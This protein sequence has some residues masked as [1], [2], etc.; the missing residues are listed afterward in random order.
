VIVAGSNT[1][2][3][4]R[5]Q[6]DV[7]HAYQIAHAN[8]IPDSRIIVMQYDDIANNTQNPFPGQVFNQPTSTGTPGTDVYGGCKK[9]WTG[10][11][12]NAQNF[13]YVITGN[14]T[15][16]KG[17]KVLQSGPNDHVFIN[18]VDHGATGIVAFPVGPYLTSTDLNNALQTMVKNQMFNELTFYMEACEAGSMFEGLITTDQKIYVTTASNAVESSWGTYCPPD[19]FVDGKEL[20][21]CLGDLYSVN[22]MQDSDKSG[23]MA[24]SLETQYKTVQT[25]TTL[26]HVMQYGDLSFTD[27]AVVGDFLSDSQPQVLQHTGSINQAARRSHD[28]D[29]NGG[30]NHWQSRRRERS[31]VRSRDIPMHLAYYQYLRSF[32]STYEER[33]KL[34][35]ELQLQL[36]KRSKADDMFMQ[37]A[38]KFGSGDELYYAKGNMCGE[39]CSTVY[40]SFYDKCG[41]FDDYSMQYGRVIANV[42]AAGK[43]AA[44]IAEYLNSLC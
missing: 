23:A 29:Q 28:F 31:A 38:R 25:E 41:G 40:H 12:V 18:F 22:W 9:D 19:D 42:C 10:I 3:N 44:V 34:M 32:E 24:E 8:G 1:W 4:Y 27:S 37:L 33:T 35:N 13:I 21:S 7:C 15:M 30:H 26:S 20:N 5:H 14:A 6:S 36:Q 43:D 16:A 17:R 11:D 39:C 2:S